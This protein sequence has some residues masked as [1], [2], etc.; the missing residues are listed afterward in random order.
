MYVRANLPVLDGPE[1]CLE[2]I[3]KFQI[4]FQ[5]QSIRFRSSSELRLENQDER[6]KGC[7][8]G[9]FV[10]NQTFFKR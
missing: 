5:R 4:N 10:K 3:Q 8:S 2:Y 7:D 1:W 6:I 9:I